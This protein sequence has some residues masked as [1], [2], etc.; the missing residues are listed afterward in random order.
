MIKEN[1]KKVLVGS[2]G[3]PKGYKISASM[4]TNSVLNF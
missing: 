1:L 4:K 3:K 2:E